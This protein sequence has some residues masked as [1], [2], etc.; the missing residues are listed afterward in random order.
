MTP[1]APD[2]SSAPTSGWVETVHL[3]PPSLDDN[4][5][6]ADRLSDALKKHL[7]T[8]RVRIDLALLRRLP[9]QLR[10]CAFAVRCA[11]FRDG[12]HW[13][14]IDVSAAT[15]SVRFAGLA[16]D[17][18][19]TRVAAR[20]VDLLSGRVLNE[21]SFDNPQRSVG[22]DILT[23]IHYAEKSCHG[24]EQ[25]RHSLVAAVNRHI[26]DLCRRSGRRPVDV[27]LVSLAGNTTM[28][29]L[30]AG[31]APRWMIREPYIPGFNRPGLFRASDL[32]LEANAGARVYIFP[33]SG[34]Y[35]GGDVVAGILHAGMGRAPE[36]ALLVDVG[37][38]AEVVVG[39]QEWMVAC[40][41]AA[42]PALEQGVT[43]MGMMAASGVIDRVA[44]DPASGRFRIHVIGDQP[45][46]G[47]CGS[48]LIDLAAHLFLNKMID[49]RGRLVPSN[50][51]PRLREDGGSAALEI[52][53][54]DQTADGKPLVIAQPD[55]DSL[56]R[57]KA[58][59][60][61]ILE[62]ITEIVGL[63]PRDLARF[64]VAG[65]FGA[66]IDPR[67]AITIGMLPDLPLNAYV[68]LGNSS[69]EGAS[70]L[71]SQRESL[72]EIDRITQRITYVELNVNQDFM[73]R[74]SAAKFIPHTD[75][76]LFPS[77]NGPE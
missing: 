58:A 4:T 70:R 66:F 16:V 77:V 61:T 51:G 56:I 9:F 59:M 45:P 74:F 44:I 21:A 63:R 38:N 10:A 12:S 2:T 8:D 3:R 68:S 60:Y 47:I 37:T 53:P 13:I 67:S 35:V 30:F 55:L 73:N 20:L 40:A 33:N 71:L 19:T 49:I 24:L 50:C 65:T 31:V 57:S 17:L 14:L 48:G 11:L 5:S 25:L 75:R 36:T 32:D 34:S 29:H 62:T 72:E 27:C 69:L 6:D 22:S 76:S 28:S 23:R 43:R 42:G 52:V 1:L 41:G 18:G 7:N 64:H 26:R 54:A 46:R 15:D 39:N